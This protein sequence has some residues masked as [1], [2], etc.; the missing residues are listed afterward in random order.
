MLE[1]H[2]E[3]SDDQDNAETTVDSQQPFFRSRRA[4]AVLKHAILAK[5][6]VPFASKTGSTSTGKR[7]VIVDGYAGAGRYEDGSPGSPALIAEAARSPA[8]SG[9]IVECHFVE[10]DA[11]TYRGLREVLEE[12]DTDGSTLVWKAR[13]GNVAEH[14]DELLACAEGVPLFLFLDPF[15]LGLPF[16]VIVDIFDGRP[17]GQYVPATEVLFRFDANAVRRIR[18]VLHKN[19]GTNKGREKTL[20]R[21]DHAAG[22]TWWRD[23]D[24]PTLNNTQYLEWFE[25]RLLTEITSRAKCAGWTAVVKQREDLQP[26][27]WLVFLTRHRDGMEVFG[28]TLSKA[29]ETWRRAV[30]DEAF[31]AR[32]DGGQDALITL[33]A[34]AIFKRQEAELTEQLQDQIELNL[35]ALL[36]DHERFI[37][38]T[39]FEEVY[40]SVEGIARTTH[41]RKA[42]KRLHDAGI[43]TSNQ[44][45]DVYS[46][47]VI[48]RP[49]AQP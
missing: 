44:V 39:K 42:L 20:E 47:Q 21:L 6:V 27:Y 34:D 35:R 16:D 17:S 43:T 24:D 28:E 48:R 4:A 40:K 25:Q 15:G 36:R 30:F 5:Y 11:A 1:P 12:V 19:D 8:L 37:V 45:G 41:L 46:K 23:E 49:G 13:H 33:D 18:G 2:D 38:R 10:Q 32:Q 7:V 29:Q 26:A 22:G 3:S 31:A 9:R 14:L